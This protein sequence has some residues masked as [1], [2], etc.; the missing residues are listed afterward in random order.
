VYSIIPEQ[1]KSIKSGAID[2]FKEKGR[3]RGSAFNKAI[4][5]TTKGRLTRK[6][7]WRMCSRKA[8]KLDN[9]E[10]NFNYKG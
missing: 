8:L 9:A 7:V 3:L 2:V 1:Q 4:G 6:I 5:F 10:G